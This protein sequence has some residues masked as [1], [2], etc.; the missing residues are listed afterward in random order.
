[1]LC[2]SLAYIEGGKGRWQGKVTGNLEKSD[3]ALL[4]G[5]LVKAAIE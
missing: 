1:V 2:P 3:K 5:E 4:M